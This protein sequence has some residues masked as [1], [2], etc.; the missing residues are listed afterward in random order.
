MSPLKTTAL[1][2]LLLPTLLS[3][4]TISVEDS[5]ARAQAEKDSLAAVL[6]SRDSIGVIKGN[7]ASPKPRK[8]YFVQG[9]DVSVDLVGLVMRL[10]G[11]KFSQME[12]AGRLNLKGKFF[13]VLEFGLGKS[14]REGRSKNNLFETQAPYFRVGFDINMNKKRYNK[15]RF[16]IGFR[17]GY[18]K[19]KYDFYIEDQLDQVWGTTK[20]V[21]MTG[22][23]G[24]ALW[25]EGVL[26]FETKIWRFIHLGW[27]GRYKFR[28]TQSC[29]QLGEPWYVPGYGPNGTNCWGGTVNVIFEIGR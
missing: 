26:G 4:Q 2:V 23:D 18:S 6:L 17:M 1:A 15:N 24:S 13:P 25:G 12:I 22:L 19:F 27:N 11:S 7:I 29:Y 3:A 20:N 5:L 9:G 21:S 10:A 16:M 8:D 14:H 28:F